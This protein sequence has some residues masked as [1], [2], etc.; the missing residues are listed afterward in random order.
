MIKQPVQII[1]ITDNNLQQRIDNFLLTQ[2]K[3][4]PKTRIYR[5]LRKGEVRVNKKRVKPEYRLQLGDQVRLPPLV[6]DTQE[7]L[8]KP[9]A[10][11]L[12][13]LKKN[14]LFEDQKLMVINKPAGI[15]VH[16]GSGIPWGIIEILRTQL[17]KGH[18]LELVHRLDRDTSGCLLLAKKRS[19]LK[20]LHR[21]LEKNTLE[22]NLLGIGEGALAKIF[23]ESG[24]AFI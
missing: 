2:L 22:K 20:E 9:P 13:R 5:A 17:P 14:I 7:A 11:D 3:N 16:G 21:L 6:R 10:Y 18:F 1:S 8:T 23:A 4:V 24:C 15:A 12:E 19:M